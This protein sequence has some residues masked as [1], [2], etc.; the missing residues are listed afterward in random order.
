MLDPFMRTKLL[1]GYENFEKLNASRVAVFGVGGVGSYVVEGLARAGI[2]SL[3][4]FDGDT[5]NDTNINRQLIADFTTIGLSK[6][7]V[8]KKRLLNINP[9]MNV[10]ANEC[11]FNESNFRQYSF[12]DYDYIVD[13]IDMVSS[14]ILIIVEAKKLNKRVIS[15]MGTGNKICPEKLRVSDI[16][17]TKICPLA[18]VLRKELKVRQIKDLKVV[19]SEENPIY[20]PHDKINASISFV[21][22]SAGLLIASEVVRDLISI[23]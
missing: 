17:S 3:D 6:V 10:C 8:M 16:Y 12:K 23:R 15:C 20:V 2:G 22:S 4:I 21:P 7:E 1:I 13:A 18:R 14:K 11:V 9:K 5:V 19:Y